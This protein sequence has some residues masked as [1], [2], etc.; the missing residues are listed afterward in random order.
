M[1][2]ARASRASRA[3]CV[4][5]QIGLYDPK[6]LGGS[7]AGTAFDNAVQAALATLAGAPAGPKWI[8][9][10]SDNGPAPIDDGVLAQLAAAARS[11]LHSFSSAGRTPPAPS[12]AACPRWPRRPARAARWWPSPPH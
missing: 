9:F 1:T 7:G 4:R 5:G 12:R 6:P 11:Q 10:L 8:M 2:R 3:A